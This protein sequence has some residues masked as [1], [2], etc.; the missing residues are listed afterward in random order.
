M[1][2]TLAPL[3]TEQTTALVLL[4]KVLHIRALPLAQAEV[5]HLGQELLHA[6]DAE[7]IAIEAGGHMGRQQQLGRQIQRLR[8][9]FVRL[10][11][12]LLVVAV[13]IYLRMEYCLRQ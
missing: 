5:V 13:G 4:H 10:Q 1:C 8:Q 3:L 2:T 11:P 7:Q 6:A 9:L 12:V